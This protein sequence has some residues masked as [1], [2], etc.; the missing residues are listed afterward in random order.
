SRPKVMTAS[1]ILSIIGA[2][3]I[4]FG[5]LLYVSGSIA[6][7]ADGGYDYDVFPFFLMNIGHAFFWA[8]SGL[9]GIGI[10]LA[11]KKR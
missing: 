11:L 2:S 7:L 9:I 10:V 3:I 4:G 5:F 1:M 6:R 8:G